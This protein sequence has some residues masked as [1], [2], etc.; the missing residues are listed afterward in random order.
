MPPISSQLCMTGAVVPKAVNQVPKSSD[1]TRADP[2][3]QRHTEPVRSCTFCLEGLP[4][5]LKT[6]AAGLHS[7]PAHKKL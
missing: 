7:S 6:G 4:C 5:N 3:V 1:Q 2:G